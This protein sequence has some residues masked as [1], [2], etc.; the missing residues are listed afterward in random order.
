VNPD[1]NQKANR[2]PD[3]MSAMSNLPPRQPPEIF[4]EHHHDA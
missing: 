1:E 2:R 4:R 3:G